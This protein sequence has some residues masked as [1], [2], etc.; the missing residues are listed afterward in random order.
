M[1]GM[2][3]WV[4]WVLIFVLGLVS[5]ILITSVFRWGYEKEKRG[6]RRD[7]FGRL[8]NHMPEEDMD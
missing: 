4:M 6:E 3:D 2:N 8:N 7:I 5:L 1:G